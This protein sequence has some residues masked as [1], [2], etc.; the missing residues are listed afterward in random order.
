MEVVKN[1]RWAL[2]QAH[3]I[4][5][6]SYMVIIIAFIIYNEREH[7]FILLGIRKTFLKQRIIHCI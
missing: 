1:W 5:E 2:F 7:S 3:G 6:D 4:T